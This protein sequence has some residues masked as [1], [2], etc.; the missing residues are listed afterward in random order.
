MEVENVE[1]G[2]GKRKHTFLKKK[3][4]KKTNKQKKNRESP[5]IVWDVVRKVFTLLL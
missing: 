5:N 4:T 2:T 3:N 1:D